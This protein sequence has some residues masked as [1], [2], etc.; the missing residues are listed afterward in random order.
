MNEEETILAEIRRLAPQM[1]WDEAYAVTPRWFERVMKRGIAES[2]SPT[3]VAKALIKAI[4]H[5]N[6]VDSSPGNIYM[7]PERLAM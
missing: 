2:V 6:Y 1:A 5:G 7:A 3:A 4:E